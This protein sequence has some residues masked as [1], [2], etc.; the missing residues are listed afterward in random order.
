MDTGDIAK[1]MI[2]KL[3]ASPGDFTITLQKRGDSVDIMAGRTRDF[4]TMA[5]V[6]A[7]F[8]CV[9][10]TIWRKY[11]RTGRLKRTR[12]GY[13]RR[14]VERLKREEAGEGK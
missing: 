7:E 4:L 14:D 12:A 8:N 13:A 1:A 2:D 11:T 10:A 6:A 5:E 3:F 9:P